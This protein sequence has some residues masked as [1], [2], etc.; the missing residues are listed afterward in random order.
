MK[1]DGSPTLVIVWTVALA[2]ILRYTVLMAARLRMPLRDPL[3]ASIDR[4]LGVNVPAV[5]QWAV[6]HGWVGIVLNNSYTLL[7]P[8]LLLAAFLPA[9]TGKRKEAQEF[10]VSNGVAFAIAIPLFA[11]FPAIGPW[12]AYHFPG[13]VDQQ[14]C[15]SLLIALR[16]YGTFLVTAGQNA[17]IICFPSFHV[18]WAVLS[19]RSLWGFRWSRIPVSMLAAMISISTM[20]T[21]WHYFI[22][23][24]GGLAVAAISILAAKAYLL[25]VQW[26]KMAFNGLDCAP[27]S[28]WHARDSAA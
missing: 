27:G 15:E 8:L 28:G 24:L 18:I 2:A 11:V 22:D 3:F 13:R 9:W 25:P 7:L 12:A 17:K 10:I 26:K 4:S 23:V 21:G 14:H 5:M 19:V 1:S 16:S 20:T 6:H